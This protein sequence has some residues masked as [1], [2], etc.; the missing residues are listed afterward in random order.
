MTAAV[1]AELW[2]IVGRTLLVSGSAAACAMLDGVPI[3]YALAR[4]RFAGRTFILTA[5]N[6][7]MGMPPVV[8]GL[9]VWLILIRSGPLGSLGLIYTKAAMAAAQ[10]IISLPLIIGF[11]A[12][13]VQSLPRQLPDL[14]RSLGAGPVRTLLL[15]SREA[16]LG[17]LA[18]V[19]AA[20]GAVV[21]EV[22]ASMIVGGNLQGSTRV[23]TTAIVTTT[24]RGE[25]EQALM[26][27]LVLLGLSFGVNAILTTI[28]QRR[29][30]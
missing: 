13:S 12:A 17:L 4:R 22:G 24:S 10:F 28:Q 11:T 21:S 29:G 14:L 8:V 30:D 1:S 25:V 16:R 23:L 19:M 26:L 7:G 15:I 27:G 5:V 2:G 20:F 6:T 3:G 9:V 18:A